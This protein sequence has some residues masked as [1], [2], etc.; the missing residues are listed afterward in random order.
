MTMMMRTSFRATERHSSLSTLSKTTQ[1]SAAPT[2]A[3]MKVK[4]TTRHNRK[5]ARRLQSN[6]TTPQICLQS[7]TTQRSGQNHRDM[8]IIFRTNG[9]C[10][11]SHLRGSTLLRREVFQ[12]PEVRLEVNQDWRMRRGVAGRRRV[13]V[14]GRFHPAQSIGIFGRLRSCVD[15][16]YIQ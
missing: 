9:H 4:L 5:L 10:T 6:R 1:V 2:P 8:S 14:C 12:S 15:H 7:L 16:T 13:D 11:K 3:T